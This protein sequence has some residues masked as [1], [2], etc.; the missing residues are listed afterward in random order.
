MLHKKEIDAHQN[1]GCANAK[2]ILRIAICAPIPQCPLPL[3]ATY[4]ESGRMFLPPRYKSYNP[5]K[6][7]GIR[8][9]RRPRTSARLRTPL[10]GM[11]RYSTS[12]NVFYR[13]E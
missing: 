9:P 13:I 5:S 12:Y 1:Y 11:I 2:G 8:I 4:A 3:W 6:T 10:G 7:P